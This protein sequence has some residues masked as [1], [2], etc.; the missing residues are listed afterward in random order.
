DDAADMRPLFETIISYVP[1]PAG[2]V[3]AP[4]QLQISAL[5][6]SSYVGRL[7]IGRIRRGRLVPGQEVMVLSGDAASA[8]GKVGQVLGF[9]GLQRAPVETA[10]A[11]DIVLITGID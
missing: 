5:D 4:L 8:R 7:G 11:G 9:S 6:Y 2:E 10:A 3:D 1:A